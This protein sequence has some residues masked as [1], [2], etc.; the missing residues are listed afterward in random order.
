MLIERGVITF[1]DSHSISVN[2]RS[3]ID[4]LRCAEGKGCGGG[5]LARW[6]GNRQYSVKAFYDPDM[7]FPKEGDFVA[8]GVQANHIVKLA[9]IMYFTPLLLLI[10][11]IAIQ[12]SFFSGLNELY[13]VA[14][15]VIAM[16]IGFKL[17]TKL[18]EKANKQGLMLPS[19][20]EPQLEIKFPI[21]NC[22]N[23]IETS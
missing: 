19:L 23:R 16:I 17:A 22:K 6:L 14:F 7:Q 8:I 4:C 9:A 12:V 20:I 18:V 15:S 13:V 21:T 5:I 2:C 11:F 3:K 1:V 10:L